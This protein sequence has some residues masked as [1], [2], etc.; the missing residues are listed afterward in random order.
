MSISE[1]AVV[2]ACAGDELVGIL[3]QPLI[4]P[5]ATGVVVVVGGPQFRVGCHRQFTLLSRRLAAAGIPVFRFDCRGMGDST[6]SPRRFDA[7]S[8]DV[9]AAIVAFMDRCPAVRSVVL[10]GLCDGASASLIYVGETRDTRVSGL[11]L[12][13]PWVRS[14]ATLAK[15]HLK[16]YYG[17]R[18]WQREFWSKLL[19]GKLQVLTALKGFVRNAVVAGLEGGMNDDV[20]GDSFQERMYSGWDGFKGQVLLILSGRDYVAKEFDEFAR[21][22]RRWSARLN[23]VTTT[24]IDVPLADHTFS[25]KEWREVVETATADWIRRIAPRFSDEYR[26]LNEC[27]N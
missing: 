26:S 4:E 8:A 14:E 21:A 23:E 24:R 20:D 3:A 22:D 1:T 27:A 2:F 18:L 25:S 19:S 16:H 10:W 5:A 13:N 7:L 11:V 15:T 12:L 17:E 6:G 9:G